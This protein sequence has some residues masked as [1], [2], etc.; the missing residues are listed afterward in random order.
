MNSASDITIGSEEAAQAFHVEDDDRLRGR[1][2]RAARQ[3]L[4]ELLL[5]LGE[6]HPGAGIIDQIFDLDRGIGRIDAGGNAAGA[7]DAHV[8]VHPFRHR[9]GDDRGDVAR[10]G[11][12]WRAVRRR[13]P[14]KSAATAASWSAAR[15]RTSSRGSPAC[16]RAFPPRSRKLLAIVSA[17]VSTAGLAIARSL[18]PLGSRRLR[19]PAFDSR[20]FSAK[21]ATR[22]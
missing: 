17:T 14:S 13:F 8:G 21:H 10:A 1:A 20:S 7:Q 6:D 9:V 5:V 22:I 18:P 3:D 19:M 15:C 16:R 4:V 11:S 12:R 2:A